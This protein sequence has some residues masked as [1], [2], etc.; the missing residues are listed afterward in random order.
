MIEA[1]HLLI[2]HAPS[3][4]AGEEA[5]AAAHAVTTGA[6]AKTSEDV[7]LADEEME[8]DMYN[9]AKAHVAVVTVMVEITIT[10]D[11]RTLDLP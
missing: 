5:G 7:P 10:T 9:V 6:K 8:M 2:G 11:V 1:D 4:L 3:L